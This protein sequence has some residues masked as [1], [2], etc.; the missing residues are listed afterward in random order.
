MVAKPL[1]HAQVGDQ[2]WRSARRGAAA[3]HALRAGGNARGIR[4]SYVGHNEVSLALSVR[5]SVCLFVCLSADSLCGH[6]HYLTDPF[7]I[8]AVS[9][10]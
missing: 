4:R 2:Q 7:V 10:V 6:F 9:V 5:P 3:R 1:A 8:V